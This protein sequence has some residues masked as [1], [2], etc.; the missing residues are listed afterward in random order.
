MS[1]MLTTV[2]WGKSFDQACFMSHIGC[3]IGAGYRLDDK[4]L[5]PLYCCHMHLGAAMEVQAQRLEGLSGIY[6]ASLA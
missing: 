2:G 4:G 3:E 5:S 6:D 1:S